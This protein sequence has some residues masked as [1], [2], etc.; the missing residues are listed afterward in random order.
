MGWLW[1]TLLLLS[2]TVFLTDAVP[3]AGANPPL[4]FAFATLS[5]LAGLA[6]RYFGVLRFLVF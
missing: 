1:L 5:G 4:A 3:I 2:A 6:L